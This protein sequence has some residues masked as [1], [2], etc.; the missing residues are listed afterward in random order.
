VIFVL[1]QAKYKGAYMTPLYCIPIAE[2]LKTDSLVKM[3]E[4]LQ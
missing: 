3:L 2:I 1:A 4:K